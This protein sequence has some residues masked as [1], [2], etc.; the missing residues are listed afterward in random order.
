MLYTKRRTNTSTPIEGSSQHE[1]PLP[2][3]IE[4]CIEEIERINDQQARLTKRHRNVTKKLRQ[5]RDGKDLRFL[6]TQCPMLASSPEL[7]GSLSTGETG[8]T[9]KILKRNNTITRIMSDVAKVNW[10]EEGEDKHKD[11]KDE[12]QSL[13]KALKKLQLWRGQQRGIKEWTKILAN[14]FCMTDIDGS[15]EID[16][17]EYITMIKQLDLSDTL[18][19]SL[20]EKFHNI[21]V[22]G[23][24]G[25]TLNE[26]ILFFHKFP[27]FKQE[28]LVHAANN[29]PY[30]HDRSLNCSQQIRQWIYC[31][32]ECPQYSIVSKILFFVDVTLTMIPIVILLIESVRPSYKVLWS[33]IE[34]MWFV[35]IFFASEYL[36]GLITC[37]YPKVFICDPGHILDVI[38]FIFWIIYNTLLR[39][40]SLDPMGF[41][42]IRLHR[43]V[44]IPHIFDLGFLKEDLD[45]YVDTLTLA[46]TSYGAV[47]PL[48]TFSILFFSLLVYSFERGAYQV[49]NQTWVRDN[50]EGESPFSDI[51]SCIWFTIVTMTTLGYGDIYPTSCVGR[52]ISMVTVLVGL[53]NITFLINIVGGCFEEVFREF[54]VRRSLKMEQEHAK[55]IYTCLK[56]EKSRMRTKGKSTLARLGI[57][58]K[59]NKATPAEE[60]WL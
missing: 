17:E 27:S 29:A 49:G 22:D 19:K 42:I 16:K 12:C 34:Y 11:Y 52:I 38:S 48:L 15:G 33:K 23:S 57:G 54:V 41:I 2:N 53:C 13:I 5:L 21:D 4:G 14:L 37:K 46:Y 39:P 26:F 60:T 45:I 8:W 20:E 25:I 51:Y 9:S 18:K 36:C 40:G 28:L 59:Q 58:G 44:K 7:P 31:I 24:G 35:S 47:I 30:I 10:N 32:V 6:S 3:S 55:Y 1:E 56:K 43:W 50:E